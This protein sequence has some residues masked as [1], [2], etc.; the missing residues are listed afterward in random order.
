M[1]PKGVGAMPLEAKTYRILLD[2]IDTGTVIAGRN[3][4][5]ALK[6]V[7]NNTAIR[8]H[9]NRITIAET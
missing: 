2:G 1:M 6:T 8:S 5:Q 9:D 3:Y 7:Y 4:D